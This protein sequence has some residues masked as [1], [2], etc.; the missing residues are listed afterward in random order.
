MTLKQTQ[1][2]L[3]AK[4]QLQNLMPSASTKPELVGLLGMALSACLGGVEGAVGPFT[5]LAWPPVLASP[6]M[7]ETALLRLWMAALGT[8]T[9]PVKLA[10]P[11]SCTCNSGSAQVRQQTYT[12]DWKMCRKPVSFLI[13]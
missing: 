4:Q 7:L 10:L 8:L 1:G 11:S 6:P 5:W 12:T 9:K 3:V 13:H 2:L